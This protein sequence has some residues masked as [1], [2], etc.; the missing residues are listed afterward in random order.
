MRTPLLLLLAAVSSL[1]C[2]PNAPAGRPQRTGGDTPIAVAELSEIGARDALSAVR[3]LRPR[4]LRRTPQ[5]LS[6]NDGVVVYLGTLRLGGVQA[7]TDFST[8]DLDEIRYLRPDQ[9]Q[10]RFGV[11]HLNGAIV[12]TPR[13]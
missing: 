5:T 1:A 7:L 13:T 11:G 3:V 9:A 8:S 6:G 2:A 12:L 4:W 10:L